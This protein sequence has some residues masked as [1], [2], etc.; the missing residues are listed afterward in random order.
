M[1]IKKA[2]TLYIKATPKGLP[3]FYGNIKKMSKVAIVKCENYEEDVVKKAVEKSINLLGGISNFI[4]K[5]DK[6]FI[7]PN[8]LRASSPESLIITHPSI[9]KSVAKLVKNLGAE[10]T[11]GDSPGGKFTKNSL[12]KVYKIS[13]LTDVSK[14]TGAK[15]NWNTSYSTKSN[16]EGNIVKFFEIINI[17]SKAD[18][19]ISISKLKTH[20]FTY[21]TGAVKN[22][23][24]LIPGLKKIGF[25]TR[26]QNIDHFSQMLLDLYIL[27][28][29]A[30]N[31]M[32]AVIA[33]EG[34]GPSAGDA[35]KVGLILA[36][37]D[38]VCLDLV[39]S[40]IIGV[41]P[42]KVPTL[43]AAIDRNLITGKISD[44]DIV[45]EEIDSVRVLDFKPPST[46]RRDFWFY[47]PVIRKWAIRN[48]NSTPIIKSNCIG[49]G[50]CV[51][52]CPV[53]AMKLISI[54]KMAIDK[55]VKKKANIDLKKCIRCYCCHELCPEE[56][57]GLK[58]SLLLK[59]ISL[60]S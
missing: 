1:H 10:V 15:L 38:A 12:S 48:L 26:F 36:S 21:I 24:G 53:N 49:C 60:K 11:I 54:D 34:S 56:A 33:M 27:T 9:V 25:H 3:Y 42:L 41:N 50:V 5:K 2:L 32:D 18:K 22:L 45:G 35:K 59:M 58:K 19:I 31:I 44:V 20:G 28:K 30:L 6:V 40:Y 7:K 4:D 55:D 47:P 43:K 52:S 29:P 8:L 14:E 13:G 37:D 51:K 57:V 46:E 39:V 23:F 16:P 17:A